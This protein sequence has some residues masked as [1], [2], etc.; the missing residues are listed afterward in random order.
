MAKL[1][2]TYRNTFLLLLL[3]HFLYFSPILLKG[4]VV[5]HHSNY[6]QVT[7]HVD[8]SDSYLSNPKFSD[9]SSVY[10]PEIQ[11]LLSN[12]RSQWLPTWNPHVQ[13]GRPS[14]HI[15]GFSRAYLLTHLLTSLIHDPFRLYT[16]LVI[17]TV[18]LTGIFFFLFLKALSRSPLA[19]LTASVGLSLGAFMSYWSTFVMFLSSICWTCGLLWLTTEFCRKPGFLKGLGISFFSYSLLYTGYPQFIVLMG[20]TVALKILVELWKHNQ[21]WPIKAIRL[22]QLTFWGLSG[23]VAVLPAYLDLIVV[24]HR[25]ARVSPSDEFFLGVLPDLSTAHNFVAFL[26]SLIDPFWWGNPMLPD[27]PLQEYNGFSLL[28][29]YAGLLAI[30]FL[31]TSLWRKLGHW[32]VFILLCILG[33]IWPSGYLFAVHHLGF[34]FSRYLL[35]SGAVIPAFIVCAYAVDTLLL[36]SAESRER[37]NYS[38][39]FTF[40]MGGFLGLQLWLIG[41]SETFVFQS[42]WFVF[43]ILSFAGL[44]GMN[45]LL[46]ANHLGLA[47]FLLIVLVTLNVFVYSYQLTLYRPVSSI[48]TRSPLIESIRKYLSDGSRYAL[49]GTHFGDV[50]SPNQEALLGLRSI[51]SYDSLSSR[52]Y[53]SLVA[54]WTD[55]GTSVYGRHFV[56]LDNLN[57]LQAA[58]FQLSGVSLLISPQP[59]APEGFRLA[60]KVEGFWLY[61]RIEP[62]ILRL[63]TSNFERMAPEQVD[64]VLPYGESLPLNILEEKDDF[65]KVQVTPKSSE[66]LLFLSQQYHPQWSIKDAEG[67]ALQSVVVNDFYQGIIIPPHTTQVILRFQPVV[68]W[69]WLPQVLYVGLGVGAISTGLRQPSRKS[70]IEESAQ[71]TRQ[72][73]H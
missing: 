20:Y 55:A 7:G 34:N 10:I 6:K 26:T 13:L 43:G 39:I 24:A 65:L 67:Q 57:K 63:Q 59:I 4:N 9:Q 2:L 33:T 41:S 44:I 62:T 40:L 11:Q 70:L 61:R 37:K 46:S 28:P 56:A 51:H 16:Y 21:T 29:I 36:L 60:E 72:S 68:L 35:I 15:S 54:G 38:I 64:L 48:Y 42:G 19:C 18:T 53:Q 66:T 30:A 49:F 25:S 8:T 17:V 47:K 31:N 45:Q 58:A 32:Y 5:F 50:L 27:F 22:L 3:I 71:S 23:V 69:S 14:Y 52:Q 1:R 12:R 73:A